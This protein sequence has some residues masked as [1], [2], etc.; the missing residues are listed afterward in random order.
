MSPMKFWSKLFQEI[1]FFFLIQSDLKNSSQILL[2]RI[3][4]SQIL[5]RIR[6]HVLG[7]ALCAS[8]EPRL[9]R[10]DCCWAQNTN[11]EKHIFTWKYPIGVKTIGKGRNHNYMYVYV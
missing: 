8:R 10:I 11:Q 4:R 1:S 3:C 2:F 5:N 7:F 6:V 9:Q